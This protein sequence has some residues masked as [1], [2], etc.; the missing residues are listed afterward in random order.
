MIYENDKLNIPEKYL[1]MSVSELRHEKDKI[2]M[3]ISRNSANGAAEKNESKTEKVMF[4][5]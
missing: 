5:F 3:Q 1:N 4:N 2:Y